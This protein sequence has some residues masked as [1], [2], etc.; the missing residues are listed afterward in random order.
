MM[1]VMV[2][3]AQP[4]N[5]PRTLSIKKS[6]AKIDSGLNANTVQHKHRAARSSYLSNL[7]SRMIDIACVYRIVGPEPF[8]LIQARLIDVTRN[9]SGGRQH[10][11]QLHGHVPEATN[12]QHDGCRARMKRR[13]S[14]LDRMIWSQSR[15]AQRRCFL[16]SQTAERHEKPCR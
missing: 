8:C 15:V 11:E 3:A 9:Y 14:E 4:D 2:A 12:T 16:W 5:S 1:E 7:V 6:S 13:K 10:A